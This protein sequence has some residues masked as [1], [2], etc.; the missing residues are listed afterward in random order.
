[1]TDTLLRGLQER[2]LE[3]TI[4]LYDQFE[5]RPT[6]R[7]P[8]LSKPTCPSDADGSYGWIRGGMLLIVASCVVTSS[9][10]DLAFVW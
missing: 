3:L 2:N 1:M 10:E 6:N 8:P 7:I 5:C 4:L 9:A